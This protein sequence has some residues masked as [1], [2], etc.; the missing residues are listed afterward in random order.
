MF[1]WFNFIAVV[2]CAYYG[3]TFAAACFSV[4][5][6]FHGKDVANKKFITGQNNGKG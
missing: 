1:F 2:L 4:A 6:Y 5:L 3:Q